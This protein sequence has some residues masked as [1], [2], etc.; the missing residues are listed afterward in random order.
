MHAH[1]FMY[2][3]TTSYYTALNFPNHFFFYLIFFSLR[4]MVQ[5]HC[6]IF[7]RISRRA[8]SLCHAH[9]PNDASA[10]RGVP[11][12][13]LTE[14]V[15][16]PST[17]RWWL[18]NTKRKHS[19]HVTIDGVCFLPRWRQPSLCSQATM[20]NRLGV[21]YSGFPGRT[22]HRMRIRKKLQTNAMSP[23]HLEYRSQDL[24]Y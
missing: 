10:Q 13:R 11:V 9:S 19:N 24:V 15:G 17:A 21:F 23:T 2:T 16:W 3:V 4:K 12:V 1:V 20:A 5:N 8:M 14:P 22:H 18:R 6:G 7:W